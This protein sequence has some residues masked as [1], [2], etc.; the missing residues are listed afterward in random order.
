M[1]WLTNSDSSASSLS[2]SHIPGMPTEP[3][4]S[5]EEQR[6]QVEPLYDLAGV[7]GQVIESKSVSGSFLHLT[8]RTYR[9]RS[10][11]RGIREI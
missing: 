2:Y 10:R 3:V 5:G 4:R 9:C 7:V 6:A 8:T 11:Y 1:G